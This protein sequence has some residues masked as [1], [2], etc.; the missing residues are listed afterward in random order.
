MP[1]LIESLSRIASRMELLARG[2][3]AD[4]VAAERM[5]ERGRPLDARE[6]ARAILAQVPGS[7]LGLALWADAAEAAWLDDEALEALEALAAQV[8][9][10][11]DVW[12]RLGRV[13]LRTAYPHAREALERAA[14]APDERADARRALLDL[15]DLDLSA[16]DPARAL[17]W[18]ERIPTDLAG[19][20]DQAAALRRAECLLAL[21][22]DAE[23]AA[24]A[25]GLA[26]LL[27]E[28]A[29]DSV[30]DEERQVGR[31]ALLFAK[32]A[33]LRGVPTDKRAGDGA[34]TLGRAAAL[35]YA[36]RAFILDAPGAREVL[37]TIVSFTNDAKVLAD[38]RAVVAGAGKIDE[39]SLV[40]AF[41]FAE[42][43]RADA[44][45][46]LVR[47]VE[48]GD[49]LAGPSLARLAVETRDE[50]SL[51]AL[52]RHAPAVLTPAL[53]KVKQALA[54][55]GRGAT[56]DA[57]DAL[58]DAYGD[59]ELE[60]W[61]DALR[62][63]AYGALTLGERAEWPRVLEALLTSARDLAQ[64][65]ELLRI[66]GL[67]AEL[68]RPIVLAVVGEF[69]AGKSTFI[70]AFLG[71]DVAPTGILPT[72]AT[73]HRVAWA[74][75][76]FARVLLRGA[77]DRVVPHEGLKATLAELQAE[78]GAIDR[79]QIYAPIERLRWV[80]ILDTPGFNAPDP[81][82]TKAA[83]A[84]FDEVHAVV[85][86]LD[87]TGPLKA[88][89]AAILKRV[90]ALGLPILVLLNKLDRLAA[91]DV[92]AVVRHTSEGLVEIGVEPA[93]GPLPFSA[94]LALKG[95][96]GDADALGQSRWTEVEQMLS[97]V[98][99]DRA[100]SLRER[101]LRRRAAT[102]ARDLAGHAEARTRE[103]SVVF[104]QRLG[105]ARTLR[106]A[107]HTLTDRPEEI[108]PK[109][110][111]DVELA[112]RALASDLRPLAQLAEGSRDEG[113]IAA[114]ASPRAVARLVVPVCDALAKR[115]GVGEVRLAQAV[116]TV[117]LEACVTGGAVSA[118]LGEAGAARLL[119]ACARG[120]AA[121]LREEAGQLEAHAPR[122][123]TERRLRALAD[124]LG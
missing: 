95:R 63:R 57:L 100:D 119:R 22:R 114:Y 82:H 75:D 40:A 19:T 83:L 35:E 30:R 24:A 20:K 12:L 101:A 96:L 69:N 53:A 34:P 26:D 73:L 52:A 48:S 60:A 103:L 68:E 72:T 64:T 87:A 107:A 39:P 18:L 58:D 70:N 54:A 97:R 74:A 122:P 50:A 25:E 71:V 41:A 31:R 67:G 29:P 93:A 91:A 23:A 33:W 11:A 47:A 55:L 16:G 80:E 105:R 38:V 66:E 59:A 8:P 44:R 104:E 56:D 28:P 115:L 13:G 102:V 10:R 90:A 9:W 61:A 123:S 21:N 108:L 77:P 112:V 85:W 89:E 92:E 42:G 79:V 121:A 49:A 116:V 17:R 88:S 5:L 1:P 45:D 106:S 27:G 81:E 86:L 109:L 3:E 6:H 37:A 124:A 99:V 4:R 62:R 32:L 14:S 84:A 76:P 111:A 110:A 15:C 117:A 51:A 2:L 98:V 46:A 113:T 118:E 65:R 94:K 43:R 120:F 78:N 36:L 7:P